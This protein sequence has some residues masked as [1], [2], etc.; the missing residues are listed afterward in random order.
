MDP[1]PGRPR[2]VH[3]II[4]PLILEVIERDP[5]ELGYRLTIW[6][7]PLL[8]YDLE[9]QHH[10]YVSRKSVSL[11]I[12]C[13]GLRWKHRHHDLAR[14]ALTWRQAN[15]GSNVVWRGGSGRSS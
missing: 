5:R 6:T 8:R 4:D 3:G 10:L 14:R 2:T 13:L 1:R 11:A 12:A 7:A 9:D 15:G